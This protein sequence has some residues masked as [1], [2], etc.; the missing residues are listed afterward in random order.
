MSFMKRYDD[1]LIVTDL[2]GTLYKNQYDIPKIN[3]D[4]VDKFVSLGGKFAVAT[5][6]GIEATRFITEAINIPNPIIVNNGHAIYDFNN[7]KIVY[8]VYLPDRIKDFVKD[9]H[10][11][12]SSVGI[13]VYSD[14]KIFVVSDNNVV[15][16]HLDYEKVD[17]EYISFDEAV[18]MNWSK[19]LMAEEKEILEEIIEYSNGLLNEKYVDD[20]FKTIRTNRRFLEGVC[21]NIDK[22]TGVMELSKALGLSGE[23]IYT[24]GNYYNDIELVECAYGAWVKNTPD[25]LLPLAKY[26]T[27]KT[28]EDG[29]F[30]EFVEHVMS[31]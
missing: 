1:Y 7:E 10:N 23:H 20:G 26:I 27:D 13:E 25:E 5:G 11:K 31:L 24:I 9:I 21:R 6:R 19:L 4:A 2:D 12:F 22:G 29:A 18:K 16:E 8:N 3:I 28:C 17:R 14:R 15:K 30:A